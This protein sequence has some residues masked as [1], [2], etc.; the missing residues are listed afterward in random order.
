VRGTLREGFERKFGDPFSRMGRISRPERKILRRQ[1]PSSW[2]HP[3]LS[4]RSSFYRCYAEPYFERRL[5]HAFRK[6]LEMSQGFE[7][8]EVIRSFHSAKCLRCEGK[9]IEKRELL[10]CS[11]EQNS[12]EEK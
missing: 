5:C 3:S 4:A 7:L 12:P 11:K 10:S 9:T 8:F 2:E 1:N 6:I